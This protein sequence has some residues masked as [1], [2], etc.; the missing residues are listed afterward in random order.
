MATFGS[1]RVRIALGRW[2]GWFFV[3]FDPFY[4]M[5]AV[6]IAFKYE[7]QALQLYQLSLTGLLSGLDLLYDFGVGHWLIFSKSGLV[8]AGTCWPQQFSITGVDTSI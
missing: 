1:G 8:K 2:R 4:A 3:P 5:P 7:E 6:T